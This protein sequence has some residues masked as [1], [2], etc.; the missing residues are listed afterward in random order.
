M[1]DAPTV[2][3]ALA[4]ARDAAKK[5][6]IRARRS[7]QAAW[8]AYGGKVPEMR[9]PWQAASEIVHLVAAGMDQLDRACRAVLKAEVEAKAVEAG[10]ERDR[11]AANAPAGD[12]GM[13]PDSDA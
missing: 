5:A 9:W 1:T 7:E 12:S 3:H 2:Y 6:W 13:E 4:D 8:D 10:R 11:Q